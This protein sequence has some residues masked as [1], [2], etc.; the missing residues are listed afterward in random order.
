[1]AIIQAF[2]P[3]SF[4]DFFMQEDY[5][6]AF[7]AP[8]L[9]PPSAD[10][11]PL[12]S[13]LLDST[14]SRWTAGTG[15]GTVS[16]YGLPDASLSSGQRVSR[17]RAAMRVK[18]MSSGATNLIDAY[19]SRVVGSG[20]CD[21]ALHF[22][23]LNS[24]ITTTTSNR[25]SPWLKTSDVLVQNGPGGAPDNAWFTSADL[26]SLSIEAVQIPHGF[27][28]FGDF[29]LYEVWLEAEVMDPPSATW[30]TLSLGQDVGKN[31]LLKWNWIGGGE[32]QKRF[33]VKVFTKAA[34]LVGGFDPDVDTPVWYSGQ[35]TSSASEASV[36]TALIYGTEYVPYLKVAKDINGTDWWTTDW[37]VGN[38]FKVTAR[39]SA[40]GLT[41][42]GTI[43]TNQPTVS[44]TFN[45]NRTSG[46]APQTGWALSLYQ[47]PGG[48]WPAGQPGDPGWAGVLPLLAL[49]QNNAITSFNVGDYGVSL[50]N[51]SDFRIYLAV[52]KADP[53][54]PTEQVWASAFTVSDFTTDFEEPPTPTISVAPDPA[55]PVDILVDVTATAPGVGQPDTDYY[56]L[57]RSIDG[58]EYEA[59]HIGNGEMSL[60]IPGPASF[61]VRDPSVPLYKTISYR[62]E[63]V[64]TDIGIP[65]ASPFVED[66]TVLEV[67]RVWLKV[68]MNPALDIHLVT[69]DDWISIVRTRSR[70]AFLPLGRTKPLVVK[71]EHSYLSLMITT[72]VLGTAKK[73]ALEEIFNSELT[74]FLQTPKG[75]WFVELNGDVT[76]FAHLWDSL[77][78]EEDAWRIT[79]PFVEVG[80]DV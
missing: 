26:A 71:G 43:D 74:M 41:P 15:V 47:E 8:T 30:D 54:N 49:A 21:W 7:N 60:E 68:P 33:E 77:K 36:A 14:Y 39:P 58:G 76:E 67:D 72:L 57:Y 9:T 42:A 48:G 69:E 10:E 13:D 44:W 5:V 2:R 79:I 24:Q 18:K 46:S 27:S 28:T 35:V 40:S 66:N 78:N 12:V 1:M 19:I 32:A 52:A 3:D 70:T 25:F 16:S 73:D 50:P 62:V 22:E 38:S 55:K 64:T 53:G 75:S 20:I 4:G 45:H 23:I 61:Q 63:A 17:I 51:N 34:T 29:A 56:N 37:I 6:G 80:F 31:P 65:V 59:F 11:W